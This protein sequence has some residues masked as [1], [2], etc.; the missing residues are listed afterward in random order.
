MGFQE[1]NED[2]CRPR[3]VADGVDGTRTVTAHGSVPSRFKTTIAQP[4]VIEKGRDVMIGPMWRSIPLTLFWFIYM[5][6]LGV[7][8]PYYGLY[9]RE[10]AGLSGTQ[11][12]LVLAIVPM[13]GI[14]AQPFWGQIADR[15]GARSRILALLAV[16][17]AL[18][19]LALG[20][21]AG[22]PALVLAT[23]GLALFTTAVL[24][25]TVSVSLAV[26]RD[27]GPHA[28]GFVRAWGTVG[29]LL[30]V[31]A[32]PW[33]LNRYQA[34]RG[35]I[36]EPGGASEPGLEI[37]F[38]VTAALVFV[39]ALIGLALP[40]EGT[41]SLRAAPREWRALL[42]TGPFVRF[43]LFSLAA[44]FFLQGPMWLFPIFVRSRGGDI[45]TIR[46]MWILMLVVEIPLVLSTGSGLKRL[47]ARGLLGIGVLAGGLRW[48]LC[49]LITDLN[50]LYA[51][52]ALHGVTVVGILL[53]GPLYLDAVAPQQLRSTAQGLLS[54][55]GMGIA[56]IAS[57][58]GAGWLLETAGADAP[59]LI[60]GI[61]SLALGC[62]VRWILPSPEK[63]K[64]SGS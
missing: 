6:A 50:L 59:Y 2:F 41:V 47:G 12:G 22:F 10:N 3:R 32:F 29:F 38:V 46:G 37:M 26:L 58:A 49:A 43:L 20:R 44:Y 40:R 11:L 56:G 30:L 63:G 13:V 17:T 55:V 35:L 1:C 5:G 48:I 16:G 15:T 7:F 23:A 64:S 53:G 31:V 34:A 60:G 54:M 9:L 45:E 24:P 4:E 8:F 52:Q 62:L 33:I 36:R 61:G 25:M 42:R 19:S 57:N 14:V 27:A 21:A 39:A 51:V 18:G 28:F